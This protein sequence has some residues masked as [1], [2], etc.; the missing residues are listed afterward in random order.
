[1]SKEV[2]FLEKEKNYWKECYE[3][4][5]SKLNQIEKQYFIEHGH[6]FNYEESKGD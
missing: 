6:D 1:M 3:I 2:D 5:L 4:A